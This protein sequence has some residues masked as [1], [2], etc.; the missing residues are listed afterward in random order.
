MTFANIRL[1]PFSK[2]IK[3]FK[4]K[5]F[6]D[7]FFASFSVALLAIP[8]S[9]AYSLLAGLPPS[10][11]LFAAIFGSII[12]A[13]WGS[14]KH[15]IA[16]PTTAVAILLQTSISGILYDYYPNVSGP[17]KETLTLE[18]LSHIVFIIGLLQCFFSLLNMGKL[19]QFISRSVILGYFA[20]VIIAIVIN[21]LFPFLGISYTS[22]SETMIFKFWQLI[23]SL[24]KI[25]FATA[26]L[27]IFG[28]FFLIYT[29]KKFPKIPWGIIMIVIV[30]F[31]A[32][33]INDYLLKLPNLSD[34]TY[35]HISF[36]QDIGDLYFPEIS[37][38]FPFF[39][40]DII[41]RVFP[42]ALAITMLGILEVFSVAR[43]VASESSQI[44]NSNQEV[45]SFGL[46]NTFLSFIFGAMPASGSISRS[47]FNLKNKGRTKFSALLS[48]IFVAL[49][50]L[51]LWPLLS[52]IPL[53]ALSAILLA[54]VP[55]FVDYKQI[56]LCFTVTKDDGI[57]FLLTMI[58]CLFFSL[59]V[60]L[61][62]GIAISIASYLNRASV[63]H[64]V[65]YAFNSSGRLVV[66]SKKMKAK[67]KVRIIGI[68]GELFFGSVDLFQSTL[69]T[70][71][72]DP[73][74][75]VIVLRLSNIYHMDASMCYAILHLNKYLSQ[76]GR[77][78]IISGITN[79]I[80]QV[81]SKAGVVKEIGEMNLF[82]TN[83]SDPQLSTWNACMR[84]KDL[85]T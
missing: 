7:D 60:A 79:E 68:A 33:L 72:K 78:L 81:F 16:G 73:Y 22:T 37:F 27:G 40:L 52:H 71:A 35:L 84:A 2:E 66:V 57:V 29:K 49:L 14:S 18:I 8:Q 26:A 39:N 58:S 59:H 30:S 41:D 19:L 31:A 70:V 62:I 43:S 69:Q 77:K 55:T 42:A 82:L 64:V 15:L 83:E 63:P 4:L 10:A 47:L 36:L 46:A 20:G 28:V 34:K 3:S 61:F 23:L 6:K 53:V 67:I 5:N 48:G 56:K 9:I 45:F 1:F 85:V 44:I 76:T 51:L 65:E 17:E 50:L 32:Y 12:V 54:I 75:K 24:K 25:S 74:V 11:G 80:W 21:Q 38:K 13:L